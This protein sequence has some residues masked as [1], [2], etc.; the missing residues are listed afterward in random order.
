MSDLQ[1]TACVVVGV[2]W[3][4]AMSML[5][6]YLGSKAEGK[7]LN[8]NVLVLTFVWPIALPFV[9]V[10]IASRAGAEAGKRGAE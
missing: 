9:L 4:V 5:T 10:W 3:Y 6:A 8:D 7:P 1:I 2:I